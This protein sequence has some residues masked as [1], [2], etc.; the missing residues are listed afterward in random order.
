MKKRNEM[1][2]NILSM[3]FC[4]IF[5]IV[6][7]AMLPQDVNQAVMDSVLVEKFGAP[8]VGSLYFIVLYSLCVII[9]QKW[10]KNVEMDG[11]ELG[12]RYGL[13]FG[14]IYQVGMFE[15][16]PGN[17]WN[18]NVFV[19]QFWVGF[20]DLV[21]VLLLA[22]LIVLVS[23]KKRGRKIYFRASKKSAGLGFA[24]AVSYFLFRMIGYYTGLTKS[25]I[26]EYFVPVVVWTL[27]MSLAI[28]G[29]IL[30]WYPIYEK[31][32]KM[33]IKMLLISFGTNWLWFNS[34]MALIMKG[35]LAVVLLR[36]GIDVV[37]ILV[38]AYLWYIICEKPKAGKRV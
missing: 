34:F 31:C 16:V 10:G 3:L 12:L 13:G 20:G 37:A 4:S 26:H 32:D 6:F 36:V 7:H 25:A 33:V 23:M 8:V 19:N 5:A 29:M 18:I 17:N 14:I 15:L 21:P 35:F 28:C 30:C 1:L 24:C 2:K 27:C 38:G 11:V 22:L 9:I